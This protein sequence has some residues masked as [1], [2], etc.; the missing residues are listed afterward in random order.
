MANSCYSY[1]HLERVKAAASV[2]CIISMNNCTAVD[3]KKSK[4][5]KSPSGSDAKNSDA[6][7]KPVLNKQS[8]G[9]IAEKGGREQLTT[10]KLGAADKLASLP[11]GNEEDCKKDKPNEDE[12]CT[13]NECHEIVE[14]DLMEDVL[15]CSPSH[16]PKL[17]PLFESS[18]RLSP[19]QPLS[20]AD[21]S[22]GGMGGCDGGGGEERSG[23]AVMSEEEEGA[24]DSS[25]EE[26]PLSPPPPPLA[27]ITTTDTEGEPTAKL[28]IMCMYIHV[29]V[30]LEH[31]KNFVHFFQ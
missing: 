19:P 18:S 12:D 13:A 3:T 31:R 1:S 11:N 28:N 9:A 23:G 27:H 14:P 29:Y 15:E 5:S 2:P 24:L 7:G 20:P 8:L 17:D 6:C 16:N 10:C 22:L 25:M 30:H 21:Q 26:L 4:L